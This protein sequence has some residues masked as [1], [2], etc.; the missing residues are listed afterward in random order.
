MSEL[1]LIRP[2]YQQGSVMKELTIASLQTAMSFLLEYLPITIT[3]Y[4][5][6]F[7]EDSLLVGALGL[8]ILT[9]QAFGMGILN[10]LATGL[11]TL[12]SQAYGANHYELCA[13]LYYRSLFLC[14]LLMIPISLFLIFSTQIIAYI[15]NNTELAEETGHFNRYMIL[16]VYLNAIFVNTK[17]FLNGQNIYKYQFY[18]QFVTCIL[19]VG[20]SYFLVV[21]QELRIV[22]CALSLTSLDLLN[23]IILFSLIFITKCSKATLFKFKLS[24]LKNTMKFLK[25]ALSIGSIQWLEWISFDFYVI[26]I[27]YLNTSTVSAHVL[28]SNFAGLLYQFSYGIS[29]ASGTFVGNEMGRKKVDMA[30]KYTK[31]TFLI[32]GI[33]LLITL[34][35]FSIFGKTIIQLLTED[36]IVIEEISD[37]IY[38]LVA[39]IMLDGLQ[40]I[41][42]GLVRAI[43]REA[44]TS[45]T[46]ILCY[47]V[48]G[49][50]IGYFLCYTVDIGLKGVWIGIVIGALVYD[51]IQFVNLI[52]KDWEF[53]AEIIIDKIM[54][55]HQQQNIVL[56]IDEM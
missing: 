20:I 12:V 14:T 18:T 19:F 11:E 5:L 13:K 36:K 29:I 25:Q 1:Q 34:G 40:A 27:S 22:G 24:Y 16:A 54:N 33:F 6:E 46:F 2:L 45:I 37:S 10:G 43:G 21:K 9:T 44:S 49:G 23:N 52:W 38:L 41:I 4:L 26:L 3:I 30:K 15:N 48:L 7:K 56:Q 32:D 53:Q 17:V 8:G 47:I 31:A 55:L 42:S 35:L 51:I 39:F 28:M 50:I